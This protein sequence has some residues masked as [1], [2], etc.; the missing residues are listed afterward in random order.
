M[1]VAPVPELNRKNKLTPPPPPPPPRERRR[2][3][4]LL[5]TPSAPV[6]LWKEVP[7]A[8]TGKLYLTMSWYLKSVTFGTCCPRISLERGLDVSVAG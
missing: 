2:A 5:Q 4:S 1:L 8:I 7:D 6:A 3:D